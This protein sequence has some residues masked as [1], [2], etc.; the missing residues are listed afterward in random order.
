MLT[1]RRRVSPRRGSAR[2]VTRDGDLVSGGGPDG[3]AGGALAVRGLLP[4]RA[5]HGQHEH[6]GRHPGLRALRLHGQVSVWP[7]PP[8]LKTVNIPNVR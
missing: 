6:R 2:G 5:Q 1:L 7:A 4:R 8:R 3:E